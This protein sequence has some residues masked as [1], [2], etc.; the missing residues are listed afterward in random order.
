[1]DGEEEEDLKVRV[2]FRTSTII[3][4]IAINQKGAFAVPAAAIISTPQPPCC[5][6]FA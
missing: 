6:P 3:H 2:M 1:M 4:S 5:V